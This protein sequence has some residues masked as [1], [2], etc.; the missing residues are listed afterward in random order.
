MT[1]YLGNK[2]YTV[3]TAGAGA[4]SL[5]AWRDALTVAP[6]VPR[7]V[8]P[9]CVGESFPVYR[10]CPSKVY[11]PLYYGLELLGAP[12]SVR[13]PA[14]DPV[15]LEFAGSLRDYQEGIVRKYTAAIEGRPYGGGLLDV[16]TGSGKTVMAL[17]ILSLV[18]RKTLI[19]VHK[20]FLMNQ[21]LERIGQFLPDARVGRIQGERFDVE[22]KDIVIGMLQSLSMKEYHATSFQCFGLLICDE[23]HHLSAEVFVRALQRVVV[24]YTLGLSA[25][26]QRKD[27]LTKVFKWFLGPVLHKEVRSTKRVV[28]I[29]K[30]GYTSDDP[31]YRT[32]HYDQ[33]GNPKYSTMISQLCAFF[34]RQDFLVEVIVRQMAADFTHSDKKQQ[35]MVIAH[36]KSLLVYLHERLS[37]RFGGTIGYY[38]GGMKEADLKSSESRDVILATY[39]MASE[40][41]DIKTLTTMLMATP[42]TDVVQCIGRIL[43]TEG[44]CP[45]VIDIVDVHDVFQSQWLKR[46][47][48]YRK[49]KYAVRSYTNESYLSGVLEALSAESTD[50]DSPKSG[51]T[52]LIDLFAK[53]G[54][55]EKNPTPF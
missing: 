5:K 47:R 31:A 24:P 8:S 53:G 35:M 18:G 11:L 51:L 19:V 30:I 44:H 9:K 23:C 36:N 1:S 27:G 29:K 25:T 41:L 52:G 33:R 49:E 55:R 10:E 3:Y 4:S 20:T 48:Y 13:L 50:S 14:G 42:K 21:W 15:S 37:E 38:V 28:W 40:G 43:R 6:V 7:M 39:A 17:R 12:A 46:M 32:M 45:T 22:G 54:E 16:M 2:G 34:P 26:M